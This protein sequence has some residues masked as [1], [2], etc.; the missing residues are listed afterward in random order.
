[1]PF[2]TLHTPD[3]SPL[4]VHFTKSSRMVRHDLIGDTDPLYAYRE[5]PAFDRLKSI[6]QNRTIH[7]SPMTFVPT[8]PRAVCF[9]ECIWDGLASLSEQYSPYGVVFSKRFIFDLGGGPALYLRGDCLRT[10]GAQIP[11]QIYPFIAPFDPDATLR[12]GVRLDWLQEREWRLPSS[13]AFQYANIEYVLV[14]SVADATSLVH[15]IGAQHLPEDKV[16]PM[17]VYRKIRHAWRER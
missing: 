10:V 5:T 9:T 2:D 12:E 7:A 4:V 11:P 3:Y 14:S 17:E 1:M 6:I 13:L 8:D 15:L 16:I